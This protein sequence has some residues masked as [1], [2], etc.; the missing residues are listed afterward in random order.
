M[1]NDG[2]LTI[3]QQVWG[4]KPSKGTTDSY[5]RSYKLEQLKRVTELVVY[6]GFEP[7]ELIE[8]DWSDL[9]KQ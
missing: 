3:G 1:N 2:E 9:V 4:H 7:K 8:I 5:H 6:N